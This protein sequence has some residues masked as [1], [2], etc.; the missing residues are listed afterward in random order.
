MF[1]PFYFGNMKPTGRPYKVCPSN[2]LL[3]QMREGELRSEVEEIPVSQ[4]L[5][6][7]NIS[8]DET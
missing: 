8:C 4:P 1:Y 5:G 6:H 3:V 7:T 2:A